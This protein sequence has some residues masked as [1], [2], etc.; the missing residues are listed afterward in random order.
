MNL[1]GFSGHTNGCYTHI[2]TMAP[3]GSLEEG[4][5]PQMGLTPTNERSKINNPKSHQLMGRE[6]RVQVLELRSVFRCLRYFLPN[7]LYG[8]SV[9]GHRGGLGLQGGHSPFMN[10]EGTGGQFTNPLDFRQGSVVPWPRGSS[11]C[12]CH[13]SAP[14]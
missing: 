9:C 12:C 6:G 1:K 7:K 8:F 5:R 13:V 10:S 2:K 11:H 3:S 14:A 4:R